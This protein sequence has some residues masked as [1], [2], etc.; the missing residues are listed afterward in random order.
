LS[1]AW[2][3]ETFLNSGRERSHGLGISL[4][5]KGTRLLVVKRHSRLQRTFSMFPGG[6]PGLGVFLLRASVGVAMAAYGYSHLISQDSGL[7]T[8]AVAILAIAIGLSL[9]LGYLTIFLSVLAAL[10]G[11]SVALAWLPG[12][13]PIAVRVSSVFTSIMAV[14]ISCLGPGAFSL[15]ARRYGRREIIIPPTPDP[16]LEE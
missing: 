2:R 1:S 10:I 12:S 11:I 4:V 6:W 14:A 15:D 5:N 16:S 13:D 9:V 8:M 3:L 7:A